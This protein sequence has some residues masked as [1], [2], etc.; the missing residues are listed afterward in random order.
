MQINFQRGRQEVFG[1]HQLARRLHPEL[2]LDQGLGLHRQVGIDARQAQRVAR[3]R[4]HPRVEVPGRLVGQHGTM[5]AHQPLMQGIEQG[6]GI[7]QALLI[8]PVPIALAR[9]VVR[10]GIVLEALA[11]S[12]QFGQH[13]FGLCQA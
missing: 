3:A 9:C 1:D 8:E 7:C 13:G 4:V 2:R 6:S 5:R 12:L 10:S 11:R